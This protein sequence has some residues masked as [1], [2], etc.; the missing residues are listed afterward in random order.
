MN[1][2]LLPKEG[3]NSL[4]L[5]Y[6]ELANAWNFYLQCLMCLISMVKKLPVGAVCLS[7]L[8]AGMS[9]TTTLLY[10]TLALTVLRKKELVGSVNILCGIESRDYLKT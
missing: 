2:I 8:I 5:E 1:L 10:S 7:S 3:C 4:Q 6:F 9:N